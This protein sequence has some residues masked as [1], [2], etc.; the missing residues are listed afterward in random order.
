MFNDDSFFIEVNFNID[1]AAEAL[2]LY[3]E[4][5]VASHG[6]EPHLIA[7]LCRSEIC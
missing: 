2:L 3:H 5:E 1:V 7:L 6:L 4:I